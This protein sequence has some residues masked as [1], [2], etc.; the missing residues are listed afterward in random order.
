MRNLTRSNGH[1]GVQLETNAGSGNGFL[2]GHVKTPTFVEHCQCVH[3]DIQR[4]KQIKPHQA[5]IGR[6]QDSP[7]LTKLEQLS[8]FAPKGCSDWSRGCGKRTRLMLWDRNDVRGGLSTRWGRTLPSLPRPRSRSA[9]PPC[10][11]TIVPC[12]EMVVI[13]Y[14]AVIN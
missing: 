10:Q 6:S 12:E 13:M 4:R 3:H 5:R 9:A 11:D 1:L 8:L 2:V 7:K 14:M